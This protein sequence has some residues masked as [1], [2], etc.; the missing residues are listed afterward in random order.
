MLSNQ[1]LRNQMVL[2]EQQAIYDYWRSKCAR[3][4]LPSRHDIDPSRLKAHLPMMSILEAKQEQGR[5]RFQWR[6]AGTG[7]WDL[8]NAE[9]QG[10]YI[11]ELPLGDRCDYWQ[12]VLSQVISNRRPSA[13]VTRPGTPLGR[14]LAQFWIRMPLS[15]NGRDVDLILGYDHLMKVSDIPKMRQAQEKIS[16]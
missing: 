14:H 13:G 10:R 4:C 12:R 15:K 7:F 2:P 5:Y 6:L 3:G 16:A 9:V 8:Y 11:D 1:A